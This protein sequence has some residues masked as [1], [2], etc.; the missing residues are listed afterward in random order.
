[1]V[2]PVPVVVAVV[3]VPAA[4]V[5][6]VVVVAVA[7]AVLARSPRHL[8]SPV[9]VHRAL[10]ATSLLSRARQHPVAVMA[11]PRVMPMPRATRTS[12]RPTVRNSVRN[13]GPQARPTAR[14]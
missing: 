7:A 12:A 4:V 5:V 3:V 1:M 2:A 13:S 6:P 11:R 9:A 14:A 10:R 8:R